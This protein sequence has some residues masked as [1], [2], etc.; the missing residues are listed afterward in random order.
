MKK[1]SASFTGAMEGRIAKIG[2]GFF[3]KKQFGP[4]LEVLELNCQLFAQS[5]NG[6]DTLGE[7]ALGVGDTARAKAAYQKVLDLLGGD[8]ALSEADKS[9]LR[10]NAEKQLAA[11]K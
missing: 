6:F 3:G 8:K 7:V 9:T 11:L 4:A 1:L 10:A 2:Y 5:A